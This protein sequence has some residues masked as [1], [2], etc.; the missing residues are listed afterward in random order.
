MNIKNMYYHET[1]H[2]ML[3]VTLMGR[4]VVLNAQRRGYVQER[5]VGKH[6]SQPS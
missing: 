6:Q 3:G 2:A 5:L 4:L 1:E